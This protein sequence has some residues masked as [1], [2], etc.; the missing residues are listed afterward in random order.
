MFKKML[1]I[2]IF[3]FFSSFYALADTTDQKWMKKVEVT[4]SGDHC[5]DDKNCFNRYHPK[6]KPVAKANEGDITVSYTH[7]T[8]P[9]KRIV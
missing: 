3:S 2:L 7:L 5:V 1:C 9:T 6:I 8:L 4:K